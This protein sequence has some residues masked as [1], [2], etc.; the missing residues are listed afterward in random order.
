MIEQYDK[1]ISQIH[2]SPELIQRTKAAMRREENRIHY[3]GEK[4]KAGN[5]EK[6]IWTLG[7]AAMSIA[8]LFAVFP[9]TAGNLREL[10]LNR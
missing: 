8:L 1:E 2:A 9:K 3:I 5:R 7:I 6:M 10:P 4:V